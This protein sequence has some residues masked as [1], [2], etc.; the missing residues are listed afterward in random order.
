MAI[1]RKVEK[2]H[3][4]PV[5]MRECLRVKMYEDSFLL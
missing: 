5:G 3:H 1:F 2:F 4:V